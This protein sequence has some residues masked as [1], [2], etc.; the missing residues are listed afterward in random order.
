MPITAAGTTASEG[1]Q[2]TSFELAEQLRNFLKDKPSKAFTAPFDVR[3]SAQG[4]D[5]TVVQPDLLVV[6]ER[7]KLDGKA[8]NG[9]PDLVIEILSPSSFSRDKWL[10]FNLY[11]RSGVR[12]Y[13]IVDPDSGTVTVYTLEGGQYMTSA[14]GGA[15][16]VPVSVLPGCEILLGEAFE[17]E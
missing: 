8:C 14:Y 3:L 17:Q 12:E 6:C 11:Q 15:Q 2:G 4:E 1:H 13:W 7:S 5:D 16:R 9:P 10:K